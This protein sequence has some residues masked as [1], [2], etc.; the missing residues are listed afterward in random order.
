MN[1]GWMAF[2]LVFGVLG[3]LFRGWRWNL[4]LAPLGEY[5]QGVE[6]C[7]CGFVSYC[8]Q[9][10]SYRVWGGFP[11]RYPV[12]VRRGFFLQI[13]GY[14]GDGA[15]YRYHLCAADYRSDAVAPVA[16]FAAFFEKTGTNMG[17]FTGLF[18]HQ[19]LYHLIC[20]FAL[21]AGVFPDP[22]FDGIC[23]GARH[24]ERCVGPDV[25]RFGM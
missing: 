13:A 10:W 16:C 15:S 22:Q 14:G 6:Q 25:C 12:E 11:L 24:I 23:E 17:F 7:V 20:L 4:T 18:F 19:L 2:S 3:H 21:G 8:G 9:I 1:Y 5:P